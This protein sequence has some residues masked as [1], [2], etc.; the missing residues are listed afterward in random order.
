MTMTMQ[1]HDHLPQHHL[2]ESLRTDVRAG[3]T[4][5]PKTLPPKW[6]YDKVG[7]DLFEQITELPEYYPTRSEAEVLRDRAGVIAELSRAGTLVEL[8][9]G[10]STKTRL[11]LDALRDAG[12]LERYVAIDVSESALV[13][14]GMALAEDYPGLVIDALVADFETQLHVIPQHHRRL[15]G[16]LGGTIGNLEPAARARF[17]GGIREGL[18]DND[19]FVVGTDLVKPLDVL[20]PA[21][22]D[23]AGV[24]AEFNKNVLRVI[25]RELG[26]DFDP[27][28]F[29]HVAIWDDEHEWIEMRL[30]AGREMDVTIPL[31]DDLQVTFR[32]GEHLRTE[33]S[34]KFRLSGVRDELAAVGFDTVSQWTDAAGRFAVTLA[35][36]AVR[37]FA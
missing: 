14:A 4:A 28:S 18:G 25:N 36:P 30:R 20:L 1:V 27:D 17:L 15:V 7:S 26:A 13:Q 6:F 24:T 19:F 2:S 37:S 29:E 8:G 11:L 10:S 16:F 9:S 33:I 22:D 23:Q 32:E 5:M 31:L 12:T 35:R 3:L 34:A 21:Y